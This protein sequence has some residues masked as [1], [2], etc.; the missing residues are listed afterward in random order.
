[1]WF[2][3]IWIFRLAC[4][5]RVQ[6]FMSICLMMLHQIRFSDGLLVQIIGKH[7]VARA[8]NIEQFTNGR[9]SPHNLNETPLPV[10]SSKT[11]EI[12]PIDDRSKYEKKYNNLIVLENDLYVNSKNEYE[13]YDAVLVL[14]PDSILRSAD[15]AG[16]VTDFKMGLISAFCE[17]H[18]NSQDIDAAG[19][20]A[21][22]TSQQGFDIVY[23]AVG[24]HLDFLNRLRDESGVAFHLLKRQKVFLL[25]VCEKGIF[26]KKHIPRYDHSHDSVRHTA[27][28]I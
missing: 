25:A 27:K 19:L 5:K 7:Y 15:L 20:R 6:I 1:M 26:F 21:M 12:V 11:Y 17:N 23:P 4:V 24:D 28:S 2:A 18:A 22:A 10:A 9:F 14:R 3:S 13:A 8:C 16:P